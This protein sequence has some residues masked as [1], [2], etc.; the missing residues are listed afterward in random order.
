MSI[1]IFGAT[2]R[3][4]QRALRYALADGHTVRALARDASKL[5]AHP[6]LTIITGDVLDADAV[7]R[8]TEGCE[9]AIAALGGGTLTDPGVTRSQGMAHICDAMRAGG[10]RRVV[11]VG[12]GGILRADD[13]RLRQEQDRFPAVFKLV[14]SEHLRAWQAMEASGLACT[15]AACPDIVPGERT[16]VYRTL[17]D[18][19]PEGGKTIS[20]E[21]VADFLLRAIADGTFVGQRVGVAY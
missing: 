21:D 13:G 2:G 8:T 9:T 17:V 10:G 12:G 7:R 18:A 14:S 5:A 19:M 3:T 16:G 6:G 15:M 20:C 11:G 4:G 1:A